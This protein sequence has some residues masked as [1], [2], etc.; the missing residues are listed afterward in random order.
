[1]PDVITRQRG[2][3]VDLISTSPQALNPER[4]PWGI[5]RFALCPAALCVMIS[6]GRQRGLREAPAR[7]ASERLV[8]D[9]LL[10]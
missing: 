9:E 1:M 6:Q 4:A 8:L 3:L 7:L 2:H 5:E 10:P